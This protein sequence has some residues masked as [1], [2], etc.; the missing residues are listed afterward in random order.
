M[1]NGRQGRG[2][3]DIARVGP[4]DRYSGGGRGSRWGD[5]T[6]PRAARPGQRS[7]AHQPRRGAQ[8]PIEAEI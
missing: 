3:S 8:V 5:H 4:N 1:A 6:E 2:L 7:I